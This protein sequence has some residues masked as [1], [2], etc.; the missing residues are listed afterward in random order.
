MAS[1]K[2]IGDACMAAGGRPA[3]N[4]T[5]ATNALKAAGDMPDWMADGKARR[6]T[7]GQPYFDIRIGIRTGPVVAGI[8]GVKK[9]QYDI[10]GDRVNTASRM[11][12]SGAEGKINISEST[13]RLVEHDPELAICPL[14]Q[15]E[16]EGQGRTGYVFCQAG[17]PR[18]AAVPLRIR[19]RDGI[20]HHDDAGCTCAACADVRPLRATA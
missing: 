18:L 9:V 1:T 15:G 20:A 6:I 8:V 14:R 19:I 12:S 7:P 13:Y 11:E 4:A 3:P 5:H 17:R 2:T 10:R 16:R